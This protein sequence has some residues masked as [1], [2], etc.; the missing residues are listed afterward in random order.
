MNK[1]RLPSYLL[2]A[3]CA[4]AILSACGGGSSAPAVPAPAP[5]PPILLGQ[6][7]VSGTITGFGSLIVDG[8]RIDNSA[9]AAGKEHDDGT[10][11]AAELK[12]G[13]HVEV[14]HDGLL[15][16]TKVRVSAEAEGVVA[17][18][19][20]VAGSLKVLGQVIMVNTDPTLGPITVFQ[21][22]TT[23]AMVQVNDKVEVH[24]LIK[25]DAAGK[26][27]LQATRIEKKTI[28]DTADR[29]HGNIAELSS[30]A[31]TFK[32][33]ALLIDYTDAKLLPTAAVLANGTEV[34][35]SI[36]L[37]TVAGSTAVKATVVKV[38]DHKAE[39]N[40]K[41]SELGGAISA[42]DATTKMLTINGVKVDAS[43]ATFN[44]PG[45]TFADLKLNAYVVI[46]GS[47]GSDG[48]LKATRIVL[49]GVDHDKTSEAEL[50][51][52]VANFVSAASFTVRGVP[53]D[54]S[55]VVL[56]VSCGTA[57]LANDLQVEVTGS[58]NATGQ[59]KA[60]AISCEKMDDAHA[61]LSRQG[62]AGSVDGTAKTF[63]LVTSKESLS[64]KW[65]ADTLFRNVDAASLS[66]KRVE[67]EGTVTGGVLL[68]TKVVFEQH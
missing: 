60:T 58:I 43:A 45:K 54:A 61:V 10:V 21:G 30:T 37:G 32:L 41:D 17:A 36:P 15:V 3:A 55:A 4:A 59:V 9:A 57:K 2:L 25:T 5:T 63:S 6:S 22:Y 62:V 42:L 66:G 33:G 18:V 65:S 49:R 53:V 46:K 56:D 14:E 23:L 40:A 24:A 11:E 34:H 44:Q 68:A 39:N 16:A 52:S 12:L 38:R 51:G 27:T 19:D 26:V 31:H 35:V 48:V 8:V 13:Q 50:H 28:A 47:Y 1:S 7:T 20:L 29:V 64:V 67:V